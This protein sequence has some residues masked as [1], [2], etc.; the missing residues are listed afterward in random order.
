MTTTTVRFDFLPELRRL[1]G[2]GWRSP[3]CAHGCSQAKG[4]VFL[5]S[6]G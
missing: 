1:M 6:L 5:A 2:C 4:H 3:A